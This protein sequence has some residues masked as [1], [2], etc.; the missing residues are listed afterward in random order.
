VTWL[1]YRA[2][3]DRG[4]LSTL[5]L[6]VLAGLLVGTAAEAWQWFVPER[7]GEWR[8]IFI[9]LGAVASG[10]LLSVAVAPPAP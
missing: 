3:R 2:W 8:D 6:P 4:D 5:I 1:F 10:L 9:N 7:V